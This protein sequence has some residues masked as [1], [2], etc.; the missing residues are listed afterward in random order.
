MTASVA[1]PS[2]RFSAVGSGRGGA[3]AGGGVLRPGGSADPAVE[4]TAVGASASG[5]AQEVAFPLL[6]AA[7]GTGLV[8]GDAIVT[9]AKV[10]GEWADVVMREVKVS[11]NARRGCSFADL[12]R[13]AR[14]WGADARS[15]GCAAGAPGG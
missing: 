8:S 2:G 6:R 15:G 14:V 5:E 10:F 9:H 11:G 12:A 3:R 7:V 1:D 13:A 4:V